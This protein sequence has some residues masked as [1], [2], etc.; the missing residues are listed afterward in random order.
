VNLFRAG[1]EGERGSQL[2]ARRDPVLWRE[3][4]EEY[5]RGDWD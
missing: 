3:V 4:E 5:K 1:R 2:K